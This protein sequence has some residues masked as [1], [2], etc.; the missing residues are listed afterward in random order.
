MESDSP[1]VSPSARSLV[2]E[3]EVEVERI[4]GTE[5]GI[6]EPSTSSDWPPPR[7]SAS[8]PTSTHSARH[9]V[10]G[11]EITRTPSGT[12]RVAENVLLER[13]PSGSVRPWRPSSLMASEGVEIV[14]S[15]K[16]VNLF[17][18][19]EI[20]NDDDIFDAPLAQL[21]DSGSE[22]DDD[23]F[24]DEGEL[25]LQ[26]QAIWDEDNLNDHNNDTEAI[27]EPALSAIN[28]NYD[29]SEDWSGFTGVK[30]HFNEAVGPKIEGISPL[31][32]FSQ[33]WDQPL[34]ESIVA[35]TNQ[36]A[37]ETIVKYT[38]TESG[39]PP[40]SRLHSWDETSVDELYRLIAVIILMSI[41]VRNRIDEYWSTGTLGMPEFRKI[42]SINRYTLLM[43]FLHFVDNSTI[44]TDSH[45]AERKLAKIKPLL[46]N[47]NNKFQEVYAP[48][49]EL[50]L[51][52]SLLLWKGRLS[53]KQCI[54]SKAARFGIKSYDLC[55]AA[56]GYV[57]NTMIYTGK[58][59]SLPT[60]YGFQSSTEKIVIH[61]FNSYL[62]K[63]FSL[64]MDNY[65]N[66]I[67]LCRFLK[68]KK[69][70]V[71]GTISR[72]RKQ[73]PD[74][75]KAVDKKV[76]RG[77]VV[78]RHCGDISVVCW[79]DVKLVSAVSTY[80]KNDMVEGRRAGEARQKPA[81]IDTY[82][83]FMGGVDLKDQKLSTYLLERKRGLKWYIKVFKRLLNTAILNSYI[84][85]VA[86][87]GQQKPVTHRAFRYR[88]VEEILENGITVS[89]H[90][91]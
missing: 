29:W 72:R 91:N 56:T 3:M 17:P 7:V 49:R 71:V 13:T 81:V 8:T 77:T 87:M 19:E 89:L 76:D 52:E 16:P 46:D 70:D 40:K 35:S 80:H 75:I 84:I 82:N 53:W 90:V 78:S 5:P 51:D 42:M 79:K 43:K 57:L 15:L 67:E 69:T 50:S 62:N 88:L 21:L 63:G 36:Y 20:N 64:F 65:Y 38:E 32:I 2:V 33:I 48:R 58:N 47:L 26:L 83:A 22:A 54:R 74:A 14:D 23:E 66:S 61:L 37:W 55:E 59:S 1:P 25:N 9:L 4:S 86:N 11:M 41:C 27:A 10:V 73:I 12:L 18:S 24:E 68:T 85:Y 39:I 30:E 45:G 28:T 6:F 31:A 34:M 60:I 44:D